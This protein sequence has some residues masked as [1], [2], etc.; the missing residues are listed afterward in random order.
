MRWLTFSI[1][2]GICLVLQTSLVPHLAIWG[3]RPD[4]L[5]V[6]CTFYALLGGYPDICIVGW[7]L[8]FLADLGSAN[9]HVGLY[10]FS[11]GAAAWLIYQTRELIFREHWLSHTALTLFMSLFVQI[12]VVIYRSWTMPVV[13][14]GEHGLW[15]Y[16]LLTCVYTTFWAPYFHWI[17]TRLRRATGFR[18]TASLSQS[19]DR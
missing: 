18:S 11:Y 2:A 1:L 14:G 17:L 6:L 13:V 4:W 9:D 12:I 5:F 3:I 7:I 19:M 10:A 16:A 8:G 15:T